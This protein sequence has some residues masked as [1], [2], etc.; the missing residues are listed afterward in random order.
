MSAP[1]FSSLEAL[2]WQLGIPQWHYQETSP[3][4]QRNIHCPSN[5]LLQSILQQNKLNEGIDEERL[6]AIWKEVAGSF[7]AQHA[8]PH[9]LKNKTLSLR[10][11]QPAMRSHLQQIAPQLLVRLQK[12]LGKNTLTSLRF[13]LG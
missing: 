13:V 7:I 8:H 12:Q 2:S 4:P 11:L 9:S 6:L 5:A 1:S 10:V 3:S